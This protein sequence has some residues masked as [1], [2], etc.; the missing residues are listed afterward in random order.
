MTHDAEPA[1]HPHPMIEIEKICVLG[2]SSINTPELFDALQAER[3]NVGEVCLVGRSADK[4][5]IVARFCRRRASD[6]G[7]TT[8]VTETTDLDQGMVGAD[9]V[10]NMVRVGGTRLWGHCAHIMMAYG[11]G[12][13]PIYHAGAISNLAV[14]VDYARRM[15]ATCPGAWLIEFT[16]PCGLHAEALVRHTPALKVIS[17]C[18]VPIRTRESV[19]TLL[20]YETPTADARQRGTLAGGIEI[21]WFGFNH[22]GWVTDVTLDGESLLPEVLRRNASLAE[23]LWEPEQIERIGIIPVAGAAQ[24]L[25]E[26]NQPRTRP[27]DAKE[28]AAAY[29]DGD[30]ERDSRALAAYRD[31]RLPTEQALIEK[32]SFGSYRSAIVPIV[33]ALAGQTPRRYFAAWPVS[34]ALPNF[35]DATVECAFTLQ[36]GTVAPA[37]EPTPLPAAVAAACQRIRDSELLVIDAALTRSRSKFVEALAV[38]PEC[39]SIS[40]AEA[41]VAALLEHVDLPIE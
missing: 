27:A 30:D 6:V 1:G 16:N 33:A 21:S 41:V 34:E 39:D 10:I 15:L 18:N 22:C 38:H 14:V 28:R 36:A 13:Q 23:P 25:N 31:E 2:G 37:F 20:G 4:L 40:D 17:G 26:A 19:A 35:P 5:A 3:L 11:L 7:V 12:G 9:F 29:T 8:T 32:G 24:L